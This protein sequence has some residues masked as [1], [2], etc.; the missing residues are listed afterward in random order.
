MNHKFK[1]LF[2]SS[3]FTYFSVCISFFGE[4]KVSGTNS[5]DLRLM[6][7]NIRNSYAKDGDNYWD[8]RKEQVYE[9]I[10]SYSPD[11]LGLQEANH[12]QLT[13]LRKQMQE[14]EDVGI[15]S[16]GGTK[17]QYSSIFFY[18]KKKFKLVDSGNFW[19]SE[20]P[21]KPSK[22][23]NSAHV[24]IC[25][26]VR[27]IE[28]ESSEEVLV[29]NTHMDDGSKKAREKGAELI[30]QHLKNQMIENRYIIMGDFNAAEDSDAVKKLKG[31]GDFIAVDSF[32][33]FN[34]DAEDVGTY[35]GFTGKTNGKKIDYIL[36]P[37]NSLVQEASILMSNKNGKYPSDHYPVTARVHFRES[38]TVPQLGKKGSRDVYPT[39][40]NILYGGFNRNK[41]DFW[42]AKG[43]GPHPLLVNI[44]GGGWI[45]GDK[46]RMKS[47]KKLWIK[48]FLLPQSI[49]V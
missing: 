23:W 49:I 47:I 12:L 28:L 9:V 26:W 16:K 25:T 3:L 48:V 8:L 29:Y 1:F 19:L 21:E 36:V 44:H 2:W 37:E 6:S 32:R 39:Y 30:R 40:A 5:N 10:R 11:I 45:Q 22:S 46:T 15:G 41:L 42:Q 14:Y 13:Q 35:N 17:G 4:E 38:Q 18:L 7:F 20:T 24:R 43:E 27:L 33:V 31:N 34:S